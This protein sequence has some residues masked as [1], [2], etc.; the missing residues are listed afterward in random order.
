MFHVQSI[1]SREKQK[2]E[3]VL[4]NLHLLTNLLIFLVEEGQ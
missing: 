4:G 2:S 3:G 1:Q